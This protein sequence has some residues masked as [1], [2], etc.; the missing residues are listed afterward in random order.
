MSKRLISSLAALSL[1]LLGAVAGNLP[2]RALAVPNGNYVALGDSV[3][4]GAGLPVNASVNAALC[5]RSDQS[6][7]YLI[8]QR[9]GVS[10]NS[11]ACS[12]AK[13]DEGI[14]GRQD[15]QGYTLASQLDQAFATG[16]PGLIT[17]TIGA[18]DMRWAQ[19]IRDCY[20]WNCGSSFDRG[21]AALYA[22]DLGYELDRMFAEINQRSAGA[23]PRVLVSGYYSPF[24]S[25]YDCAE[26]E[27]ITSRE[28]SF[29]ANQSSK[30][31]N[32]IRRAVNRQ[33]DNVSFVSV[34]FRGHELCAPQ[35]WLQGASAAAPFHP[36]AAG[37]QAI[38]DAF[39]RLRR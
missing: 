38:A 14:Y 8:G 34:S 36:T 19:F 35:S 25:R 10:V 37:Q 16:T 30:L 13:A 33:A 28:K 22:A 39:L 24:S 17:V 7:P 5:G 23:P 21:R 27:A 11:F 31:N 1:C 20:V 29:I 12:G 32:V 18:N 15:R 26:T 3:A 9:L 2:A 6:Y 4:A